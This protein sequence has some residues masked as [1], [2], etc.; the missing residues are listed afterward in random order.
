ME[1]LHSYQ[2]YSLFDLKYE[3]SYTLPYPTINGAKLIYI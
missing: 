2:Q 1:I 3:N